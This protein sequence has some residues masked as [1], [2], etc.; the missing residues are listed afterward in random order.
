MLLVPTFLVN[1]GKVSASEEV[2]QVSVVSNSCTLYTLGS[3]KTI[4]TISSLSELQEKENLEYGTKLN[5][6]LSQ[7]IYFTNTNNQNLGFYAVQKEG[8]SSFV[9]YVLASCVTNANVSSLQKTLDPNAKILN[10]NVSVYTSEN[11]ADENKLT[12]N[13]QAVVLNQYQEIKILDGYNKK[14]ELTKIMF[15]NNGEILTAYV[16]TK[17]ILVKGFNATIILVVFIFIVVA[18]IIWSIYSTTRKKRKKEKARQQ[19]NLG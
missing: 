3:G 1:V 13:G 14:K 9:G 6:V 19:K 12:I 2:T 10:N 18:S 5:L 8:D 17:D 7:I 11:A 16:K 4:E 15:E